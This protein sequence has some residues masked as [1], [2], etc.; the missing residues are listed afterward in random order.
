MPPGVA[1]Q[2]RG[3]LLT[4]RGEVPLSAQVQGAGTEAALGFLHRAQESTGVGALPRGFHLKT[5]WTGPSAGATASTITALLAARVPGASELIGPAAS[6]LA[7]QAPSLKHP[8][9]VGAALHAFLDLTEVDPAGGRWE[10]VIGGLTTQ[11]ILSQDPAG[12]WTAKAGGTPACTAASL[13]A[14]ALDRVVRRGGDPRTERTASQA[15]EWA[16]GKQKTN[17]YFYACTWSGSEAVNPLLAE[18]CDTVEGLL[19]VGLA[20]DNKHYRMAAL[21]TLRHLLKQIPPRGAMYGA[22]TSEWHHERY[23]DPG[24]TAHL[25]RLCR[26]ALAAPSPERSGLD[27]AGAA[28]VLRERAHQSRLGAVLGPEVAGGVPGAVPVWGRSGP[29]LI[30]VPATAEV[31]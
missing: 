2:W 16:M 9:G 28:Q 25:A 8:R 17:G 4:W 24:G 12:T 5:G 7:G 10:G 1:M 19:R 15:C 6:W 22:W 21:T 27:L 26:M 20:R 11:L 14:A 29:W 3:A 18:L 13:A 31:I 23:R 30:S